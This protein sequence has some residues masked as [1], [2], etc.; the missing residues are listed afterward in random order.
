[1]LIVDKVEHYSSSKGFHYSLRIIRAR[2]VNSKN[3]RLYIEDDEKDVVEVY[4]VNKKTVML[5]L[6]NRFPLKLC[7]VDN[8]RAGTSP[9]V[10]AVVE[11][12]AE[13]KIIRLAE[14]LKIIPKLDM[15][16]PEIQNFMENPT[17][18]NLEHALSILR[19]IN[20]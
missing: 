6:L 11:G 2:R 4:G 12:A 5:T 1:L 13:D 18:E 20:C 10:Q 9:A 8:G 15:K 16:L 7:Q 19:L 14:T 3:G 17:V